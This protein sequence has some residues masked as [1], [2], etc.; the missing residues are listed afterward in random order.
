VFA[1]GR[2]REW[3]DLTM[4]LYADLPARRLRQ[5]L[6]D[7]AGLTWC[8]LAVLAARTVHAAISALAAPGRRLEESGQD[9]A[10]GLASTADR[11]SGVPLVGDDTSDQ[12]ERAADAAQGVADAG[13]AAQDVV[14]Q[15]ATLTALSLVLCAVLAAAVVWLLPRALWVRRAARTRALAARPD[16]VDLLALRALA[17]GSVGRLATLGE[18]VVDGWRRGDPAATERLAA[19]QLARIGLAPAVR[20]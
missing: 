2:R 16:G 11:I 5:V 17:T 7:V 12:V 8:L 14:D 13:R 19:V 18:G 20:R 6:A 15:V 9:L 10:D 1:A 4:L 3:Y